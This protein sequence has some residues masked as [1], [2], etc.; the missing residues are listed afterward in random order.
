MCGR[1]GRQPGADRGH[2]L[3]R[4]T[5]AGRRGLQ[6]TLAGRLFGGFEPLVFEARRFH[7]VGEAVIAEGCSNFRHRRAGKVAEAD[8]IARS[9]MRDG[10]ISGGR[11]HENTRAVAAARA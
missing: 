3:G 10:G 2:R 1:H 11:F 7:D 9:D 6:K 8:W 5:P 4:P